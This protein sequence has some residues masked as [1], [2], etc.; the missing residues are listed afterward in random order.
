M[1]CSPFSYSGRIRLFCCQS[2][3]PLP[4]PHSS[5]LAGKSW[6]SS[7]D[8]LLIMPHSL[9][10]H[11][12]SQKCWLTTVI[13]VN[14]L[15]T[16]KNHPQHEALS[17]FLSK[18][19]VPE[20]VLW[21]GAGPQAQVVPLVTRQHGIPL[22]QPPPHP[23][24]R[25]ASTFQRDP[26]IPHTLKVRSSHSHYARLVRWFGLALRRLDVVCILSALSSHKTKG[27][28]SLHSAFPLA[29]R[30]MHTLH[31][32]L[33]WITACP[34]ALRALSFFHSAPSRPQHLGRCA[35]PSRLISHTICSDHHQDC[36]AW[37]QLT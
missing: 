29:P 14:K 18:E 8:R 30:E 15:Q 3:Y 9:C 23:S 27:I 24:P 36:H 5:S 22:V 16:E 35:L 34:S 21:A 37:L 25:P 32:L 13:W 19:T 4:P 28:I 6:Q 10:I 7:R 31:W 1:Q 11:C 12:P 26:V 33:L 20:A 2:C 17:P